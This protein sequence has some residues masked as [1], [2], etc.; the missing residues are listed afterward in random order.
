M[1]Q[2]IS[3]LSGKNILSPALSRATDTLAVSSFRS[4]ILAPG[5]ERD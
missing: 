1:M 2:R 4:S 3:E 5:L